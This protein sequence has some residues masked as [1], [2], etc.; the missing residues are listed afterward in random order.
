MGFLEFLA[1]LVVAITVSGIVDRIMGSLDARA[2]TVVDPE[3]F[4]DLVA[5]RV[6]SDQCSAWEQAEWTADAVIDRLVEEGVL[7]EVEPPAEPG[8]CGD[9]G[10][11][12]EV[13][14]KPINDQ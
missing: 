9:P 8:C 10:D 13:C 7:V 3:E 1:L 6:L 5:E 14:A 4:A 2:E 11:C 12:N